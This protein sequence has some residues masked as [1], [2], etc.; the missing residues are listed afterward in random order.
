[1]VEGLELTVPMSIGVAHATQGDIMETVLAKA[2]LAMYDAKSRGRAR[3]QGYE[4]VSRPV[5][6]QSVLSKPTCTERPLSTSLVCTSM[7]SW[8]PPP[9]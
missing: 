7:P 8:T 2:D 1:M 5:L 9:R 3:V 6:D 4:D